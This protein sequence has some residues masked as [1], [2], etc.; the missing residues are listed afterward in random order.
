MLNQ[1]DEIM[2]QK[3]DLVET[4]DKHYISVV[5]KP[6]G[7]KLVNIAMMHNICDND[8]S[9]NVLNVITEA[10]KNHSS[11]TKTKEI[12]EKNTTE[13]SFKFESVTKP[14][15]TTLLKNIDIKKPQAQAEYTKARETIDKYFIWAS[16]KNYSLNM[17]IYPDA[18]KIAVVSPIDKG[19]DNKNSIS[20]FR[21]V[22]VLSVFSKKINLLCTW[23]TYFR[24]FCLLIE[25]IIARKTCLSD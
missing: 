20:N 4:F 15:I 25:K 8:T 14:Y 24:H 10:Y 19:A 23:K 22:C 21:S 11:V 2:T 12:I 17:G 1:K 5:E 13:R 7:I 18:A 3:K 9:I 6:S 16:Y